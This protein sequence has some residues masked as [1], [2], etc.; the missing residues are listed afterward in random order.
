MGRVAAEHWIALV[1]LVLSIVFIAQN[2]ERISIDVF[3]IQVTS[4]LW[5]ILLVLFLVGLFVGFVSF[6][7]RAT[8]AG[9]R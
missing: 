9:R 3:S 6:R 7:R 1:L 2:R 4:P 5:L 8:D